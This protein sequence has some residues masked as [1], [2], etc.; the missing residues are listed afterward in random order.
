M[1]FLAAGMNTTS[2]FLAGDPAQS[3]VEGGDF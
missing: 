1:Y 2:L 3:V